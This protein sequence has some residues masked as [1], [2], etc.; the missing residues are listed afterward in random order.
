MTVKRA[1][2][3]AFAS[4]R[5]RPRR[6]LQF[7]P[8]RGNIIYEIQPRLKAKLPLMNRRPLKLETA[9]SQKLVICQRITSKKLHVSI[10]E[11]AIRSCDTGQRIRC[12]DICQLTT[13]WVCNIRLQQ[14]PTL[15]RKCE[16]SHGF[17]VVRTDWWTGERTNGHVIDSQM[18]NFSQIWDSAIMKSNE[19]KIN[20]ELEN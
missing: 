6:K 5:V 10:P 9:I 4:T 2:V 15:P 12:F 3:M 17:P 20:D 8:F 19:M 1:S 16:I 11:P 13:T 18:T 7:S 14:A